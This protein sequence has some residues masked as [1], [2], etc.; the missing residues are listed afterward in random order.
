M[1]EQRDELR[2]EPVNTMG[3]SR[4]VPIVTFLVGVFLGAALVKPWDL[5]LPASRT[6]IDQRPTATADSSA[7][8]TPTPSPSGPPAECAFAGGWRVFALGQPDPL[9]GDGSSGQAGASDDPT[10]IAD[11]ANPLRRWLEVDPLTVASGPGDRRIP[12]VTIVSDR[13]GGIGYCPPPD[14]TDGPPVGARLDAWVL[15]AK[16]TPTA[17]PLRAVTL[18]PASAIEVAVFIG[19]DHPAGRTARWAPGRYIFAVESPNVGAYGRWFGVE[20]R[21][22]PG[23]L[24]N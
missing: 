24:S 1:D 22:P 23:R 4:T 16:G 14:G 10:R 15:D 7:E 3:V 2:V 6:S 20:I 18:D 9:G 12:F 19:E 13:I 5:L 8:P 11:V 17:L 21:T